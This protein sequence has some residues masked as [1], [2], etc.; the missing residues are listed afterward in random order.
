M[1]GKKGP[2]KGTGG[3]G[4]RKLAGRGPT[5]KAEERPGHPAARRAKAAAKRT[6]AAQPATARPAGP[7]RSPRGPQPDE[8]VAGRN[9]V[10]EALRAGIPAV[11]LYLAAALDRDQRVDE[12][13]KLAG[14]AEIPVLEASRGELDRLAGGAVHQGVALAARPFDYLHPD[15]LLRRAQEAS[16]APLVV[17][18][19]GVTD[20]HN[21]GAIARSA[22]AFGADGL[23]VPER[24]SV[25]V[26]AAA[27]KASAGTLAR[28]P[29]AKAGN[30]VR[31]LAS[32]AEA[33]LMVAGL[34]G[35]GEIDLDGLELATGPLVLV[36]GAEGRGLSRLVGERCD[37][38]VRIPLAGSVES[39]NASVAA[40]VA[41]AE[42]ARRRRALA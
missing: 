21:L 38:T 30:L 24:R 7:R 35:R 3:H 41:L 11:A 10:V 16:S 23:V 31:T 8:V 29:V 1:A 26:T 42:I 9:P 33:G 19:D 36:V 15:D 13:R 25:G 5:P 28:L 12:I 40:G 6:A 20:P 18:L 17:A 22:A 27:W 34:D 32:Y 39:L 37:L 2:S 14:D 4:R